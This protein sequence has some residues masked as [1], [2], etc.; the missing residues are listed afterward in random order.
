MGASYSKAPEIA[1]LHYHAMVD[2]LPDARFTGK[3][4]VITGT[5]S[6]TGQVLALTIARRGGN[7][8]LLNRA[9]SR[10]ENALAQVRAAVTGGATV[11]GIDCDLQVRG[12]VQ[13][14]NSWSMRPSVRSVVSSHIFTPTWCA[15]IAYL[16]L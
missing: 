3:T 9:S 10:A 5:T 11:T 7:T 15:D 16:E 14:L 12:G 6:G 2:A 13:W 8:I 4:F 1:T